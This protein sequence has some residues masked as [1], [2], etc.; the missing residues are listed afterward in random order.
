[1]TETR[2]NAPE[3]DRHDL[4]KVSI[5]EDDRIIKFKKPCLSEIHVYRK[6]NDGDFEEIGRNV[7]FP[8]PDTD[9]LPPSSEVSYKVQVLSDEYQGEYQLL[10]LTG[11]GKDK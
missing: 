6:I 8:F 5:S 11:N 1:M 7:R 9:P 3:Q 4:L 10:V 2:N